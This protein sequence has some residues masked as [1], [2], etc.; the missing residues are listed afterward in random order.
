MSHPVI[1]AMAGAAGGLASAVLLTPF[2]VLRVR[3]QVARHGEGYVSARAAVRTVWA[4]EGMRGFWRGFGTAAALAPAFW[5]CYYPL[6]MAWSPWM[7]KPVA[8]VVA[9]LVGDLVTYPA[10]TAR[11]RLQTQHMHSAAGEHGRVHF[12][13]P[14]QAVAHIA[15]VEGIAALY[16]GF[17]ASCASTLQYALLFPLYDATKSWASPDGKPPFWLAVALSAGCK[18]IASVVSYPFELIR[19]R[20]QDQAPSAGRKS[21]YNGSLHALRSICAHEGVTGLYAGFGVHLAR[22][23]PGTAVTMATYDAV[24]AL[25]QYEEGKYSVRW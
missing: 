10:W 11:T 8:A 7:S 23:V 9:G 1:E 22:S 20:L 2:D 12:R 6:Y 13:G 5:A 18:S 17:P 24:C 3:L 21:M 19:A 25:I 15:R 14:V 16:A 4:A